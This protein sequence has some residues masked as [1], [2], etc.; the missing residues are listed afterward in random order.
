[1]KVLLA[2][3]AALACALLRRPGPS[4]KPPPAALLPD[5]DQ[6]PVGCPGG[7]KGDPMACQDWDVCMVEKADAP[8]PGC[9]PD[10]DIKAVRLRFTT[11]EDNVGDG[12]LLVYGRRR[13]GAQKRM[14]V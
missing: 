10:G 13:S 9:M 7:W 2:T 6:A 8:N 1:M 11:T 12:P 14:A 4:P 5:I 3:L